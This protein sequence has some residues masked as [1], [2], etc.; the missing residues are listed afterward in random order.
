MSSNRHTWWG[1]GKHSKCLFELKL[2]KFRLELWRDMP[3]KE[4]K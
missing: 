4:V 3:T 1:N 2:G